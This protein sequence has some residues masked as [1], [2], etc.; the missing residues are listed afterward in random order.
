MGI[1]PIEELGPRRALREALGL[2]RFTLL[3][4]GRLVPIKGLEHLVDAIAGDPSFELVVVG[5]GPSRSVLAERARVRDARVRFVGVDTGHRKT[6]L[7]RAAD[8]FV[9]PSVRLASG[10]SE[11]TPT[12]AIEAAQV[13]L[14]IVVSAVGGLRELVEHERSGLLVPPGDV[15]AL[16]GALVR[17]RDDRDL[18]RR[19]ARGAKREGARYLWSELAPRLEALLFST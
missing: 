6:S 16:R 14:P 12:A 4:V 10:R 19:L 9:M 1:D 18:R 7:L 2:D 15:A 11:G 3:F 8:A 17:L 5:D 13:G